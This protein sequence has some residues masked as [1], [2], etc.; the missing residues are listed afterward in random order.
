MVTSARGMYLTLENGQELL[1]A[2]CGAAV[3]AIGHGNERVKKAIVSQLNQVEYCHP[4]YFPN[5]PAVQLAEYLVQSTEGR[6]SRAC[7]LGS[8]ECSFPLSCPCVPKS[9]LDMRDD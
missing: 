3:S 9:L 7:I 4:G 2:T 6:M 5:T 1:D 8:G